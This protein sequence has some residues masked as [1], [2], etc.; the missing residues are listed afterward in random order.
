MLPDSVTRRSLTSIRMLTPNLAVT[1][2]VGTAAQAVMGRGAVVVLVFADDFGRGDFAVNGFRRAG[3][4]N[5]ISPGV[6]FGVVVP[7]TAGK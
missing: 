4:Q 3:K 2:V 7:V 1:V 5:V 6:Y